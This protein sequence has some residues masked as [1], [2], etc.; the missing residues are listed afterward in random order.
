MHQLLSELRPRELSCLNASA[1]KK[2]TKKKHNDSTTWRYHHARKKG[3]HKYAG[4]R[5]NVIYFN[6]IGYIN[7]IQFVFQFPLWVSYFL[8][9]F[10]LRILY[11][12]MSVHINICPMYIRIFNRRR[13]LIWQSFIFNE[14]ITICPLLKCLGIIPKMDLDDEEQWFET[15]IYIF[16]KNICLYKPFFFQNNS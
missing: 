2:K 8:L 15:N 14:N 10:V 13:R 4:V 16:L 1:D 3:I 7:R 6:V 11:L 5:G 9:L 12:C